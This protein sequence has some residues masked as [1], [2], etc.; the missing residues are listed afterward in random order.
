MLASLQQVRLALD[1]CR[2]GVTSNFHEALGLVLRAHH[3]APTL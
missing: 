1:L 3:V 2:A